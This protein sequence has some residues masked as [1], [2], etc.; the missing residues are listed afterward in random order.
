MLNKFK[1]AGAQARAAAEEAAKREEEERSRREAAQRDRRE[2]E[3]RIKGLEASP[4]PLA[5]YL[6]KSS[7]SGVCYP[8]PAPSMA[9]PRSCVPQAVPL[10]SWRQ[11]C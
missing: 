9:D 1:A 2:A 5:L 10:L 7:S 8:P 3:E 11:P 4:G 6:P